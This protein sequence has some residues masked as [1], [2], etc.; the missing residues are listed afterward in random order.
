MFGSVFE[1]VAARRHKGREVDNLLIVTA[2]H[3]RMVLGCL[4]LFMLAVA[5]WVVFGG[6]D[7][8]VSFDC[9][10]HRP[11]PD[12]PWRATLRAAPTVAQVID[13]G[14]AARIEVPASGGG[15]PPEL[16][17]EVV[18]PTRA[19]LREELAVRLP[20]PVDNA[21][22]IDIDIADTGAALLM[23]EGSRCRVRI[24]LGRQS[25]ADLLGFR[26]S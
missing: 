16:R 10:I 9:V 7:R 26:P 24:S 21:R 18:P 17:G 25:I 6:V 1:T 23:T 2:P 20:W 5:V 12:Q 22:R 15:T 3:E 8:I 13:S 11:V 14:M 19:P 4:A